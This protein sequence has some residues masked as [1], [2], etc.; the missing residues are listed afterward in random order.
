[1]G[2]RTNFT[3][4]T[5]VSS[6]DLVKKLEEGIQF[7]VNKGLSKTLIKERSIITPVAA[8]GH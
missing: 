8:Q 2:N 4:I 5:G 3:K 7:L 1:M 6:N